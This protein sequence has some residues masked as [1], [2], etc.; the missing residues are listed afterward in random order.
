[1]VWSDLQGQQQQPTAGSKVIAVSPE[2]G[3]ER[4]DI[5]VIYVHLLQQL[6]AVSPEGGREREDIAVLY[7]HLLQ[8]VIAVSHEPHLR[9][10]SQ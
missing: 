1:V 6:I 5:D 7:V 2:G 3:R 9:R 4:E 10:Q 8:Q